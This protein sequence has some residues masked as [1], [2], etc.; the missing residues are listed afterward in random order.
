MIDLEEIRRHWRTVDAFD[1]VY[2]EPDIEALIETIETLRDALQAVMTGAPRILAWC[3]NYD[4]DKGA[5]GK[6]PGCLAWQQAKASLAM[7]RD[8]AAEDAAMRASR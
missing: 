4:W 7:V 5:C 6:C 3:Q 2:L 1:E 8:T